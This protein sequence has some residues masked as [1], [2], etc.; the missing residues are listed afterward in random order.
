MM[1]AMPPPSISMFLSS[2]RISA[3]SFSTEISQWRFWN[4]EAEGRSF[5]SLRMPRSKRMGLLEDE[6]DDEERGSI[7]KEKEGPLRVLWPV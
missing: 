3:T 5:Q 6:E 2:R 4:L 1:E 7:K